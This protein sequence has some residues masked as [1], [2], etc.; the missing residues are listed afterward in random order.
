MH[1]LAGLDVGWTSGAAAG[2]ILRDRLCEIAR[3]GQKSGAGYYDYGPGRTPSP[4]E[5]VARIVRAFQQEGGKPIRKISQEEM[6]ER[7]MY[8]IANEGARLLEEGKAL[9]AADID[10]IWRLGYG[11]PDYRGGPMYFAGLM[12]LNNVI[13][14]LERW[15]ATPDDQVSSLL[16]SLAANDGTLHRWGWI[17]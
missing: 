9:R 10:L 4:S 5:A 16:V 14:S 3:F 7:L 6:I 1:D 2:D 15:S 8:P 17:D 11:W 13:R 12:G